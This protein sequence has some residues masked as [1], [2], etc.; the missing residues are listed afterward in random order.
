MSKIKQT[1][2]LLGYCSSVAMWCTW[3]GFNAPPQGYSI[4]Y[5]I[6]ISG[7]IFPLHRRLCRQLSAASALGFVKFTDSD[8][9]ADSFYAMYACRLN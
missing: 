1:R 4:T 6:F 9:S 3:D 8:I 2:L 5:E 7:R